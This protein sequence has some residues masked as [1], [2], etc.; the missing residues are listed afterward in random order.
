[1]DLLESHIA[2]GLQLKQYETNAYFFRLSQ[3][4]TTDSLLIYLFCTSR[5]PKNGSASS[6]NQNKNNFMFAVGTKHVNQQR[7]DH[8]ILA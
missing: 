3:N 8:Q 1:M 5:E 7:I 2:L 6:A 4:L